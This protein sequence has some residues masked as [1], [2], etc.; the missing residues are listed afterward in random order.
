MISKAQTPPFLWTEVVS[1]ANY[2]TN[3]SPTR[4]N[5]GISPFQQLKHT[6]PDL[7][8]LRVFGCLAYVHVPK[9]QRRKLD[10]HTSKCIFVGYSEQTK[11]YRCYHPTTKNI[12]INKDVRFEKHCFWNSPPLD[13]PIRPSISI[14]ELPDHI[15]IL[16]VLDPPVPAS[17]QY[18]A[19]THTQ[20]TPP[21]HQ[22]SSVDLPD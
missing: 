13:T 2:L 3:R 12:I 15:A 1:T 8:H 18:D 21:P 11:G 10:E 4:A 5:L 16:E 20:L 19:T 22:T 14:E 9:G 6:I 7:Q 17:T